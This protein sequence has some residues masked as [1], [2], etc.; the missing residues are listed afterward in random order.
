MPRLSLKNVTLVV[1]ETR[2]HELMRITAQEL[3]DVIDFGEV[4]IYSDNF[5]ALRVPVASYHLVPDWPSKKEWEQFLW[6]GAT[7]DIRTE[8]ALMVQWDAGLF[9]PEMWSEAFLKYDY[10]GAPWYFEHGLNVGNGGF[11]INSR[12]LLRYI[13]DHQETFPMV[14]PLDVTLCRTYR[15][16]LEV[17]GFRWAPDPIALDFAFETVR[18]DPTSRHFGYHGIFNWPRVL[19]KERLE[20]RVRLAQVNPYIKG[21]KM[22]E[23]LYKVMP[24]L[25]AA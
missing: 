12:R 17:H 18:P 22:L 2:A 7:P 24:E 3:V 20:R 23:Q 13:Y 14:P 19:N 15:P 16:A 9:D 6:V 5:N 4:L 21:T 8:F 10:I 1:I 25:R 11:T